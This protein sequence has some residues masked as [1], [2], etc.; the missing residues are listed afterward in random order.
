MMNQEAG[1]AGNGNRGSRDESRSRRYGIQRGE[2]EFRSQ[3]ARNKRT[4][5]LAV[6]MPMS[7]K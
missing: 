6:V 4:T 7:A 3:E 1:K 2:V 5:C